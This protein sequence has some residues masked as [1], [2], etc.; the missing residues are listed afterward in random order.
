MEDEYLDMAYEDRYYYDDAQDFGCYDCGAYDPLDCV[1]GLEEC[2][3]CGDVI[4][5]DGLCACIDD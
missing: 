4:G 2:L 5:Y 1:C 3:D